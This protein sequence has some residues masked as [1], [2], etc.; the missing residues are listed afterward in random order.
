MLIHIFGGGTQ[1]R[2]I[3]ERNKEN[4]KS[5]SYAH[6]IVCVPH[7]KGE[8]QQLDVHNNSIFNSESYSSFAKSVN[9]WCF[10]WA[11]AATRPYVC[12]PLPSPNHFQPP[13]RPYWKTINQLQLTAKWNPPVV[14]HFLLQT[15]NFISTHKYHIHIIYI[16]INKSYV[17]ICF[18]DFIA[19]FV[20]KNNVSRVLCVCVCDRRFC[21]QASI[22]ENLRTS[23]VMHL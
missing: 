7:A 16:Y 1:R 15:S 21:N 3:Q 20:T 22:A 8:K 23:L 12:H 13:K 10:E 18:I 11:A 4:R 9:C 2:K 6:I 5:K 19:N 17:F 14:E